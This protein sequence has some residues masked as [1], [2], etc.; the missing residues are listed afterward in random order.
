MTTCAPMTTSAPKVYMPMT[1][2]SPVT[3]SASKVY[4]P[5]TTSSPVT[6]SASKVYMPMTTSAPRTHLF[7]AA[8][9]PLACLAA[10]DDL[11]PAHYLR[12][13]Y[14]LGTGHH[15]SP[16]H[17]LCSGLHE[18]GSQVPR[19]EVG[20]DFLARSDLFLRTPRGVC[21]AVNSAPVWNT[22]WRAASR[23][24]V[25]TSPLHQPTAP[26]AGQVRY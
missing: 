9:A 15:V 22:P 13:G 21:L 23:M 10:G 20:S 14:D 1:T 17:N 26:V 2:S 7:T 11:R 18:V 24:S 12:S 3:T 4:M 8:R 19:F 6:T 16:P 5:M 25:P